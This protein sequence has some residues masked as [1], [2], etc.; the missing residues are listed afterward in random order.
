M[1][2]SLNMMT[3][4]TKT[5][6]SCDHKVKTIKTCMIPCCSSVP[7]WS[8]AT[9]LCQFLLLLQGVPQK[10]TLCTTI[11]GKKAFFVG[12]PVQLCASFVSCYRYV[13]VWS[14][15]IVL[16]QVGLLIQFC[17]S[18]VSCYMSLPV[19]SPANV[20]CQLG[21]TLQFCASVVF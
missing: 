15:A 16:C 14:P 19:W 2:T 20:L 21:F 3:T 18:V 5:R 17:V 12:N 9:V 10:T 7:V 13:S 4:Q 8:S 11:S 1:N 6:P